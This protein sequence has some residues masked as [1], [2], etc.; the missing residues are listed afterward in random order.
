MSTAIQKRSRGVSVKR[1]SRSSAAA[2]ATEWT[3]R[4]SLPSQAAETS[5][6]T[7]AMSSSERTS[8]GVTS[9]E[10]TDDASSR[11]LLSI[12]SP[13]NV[14]ASSA[15]SSASRRAIAHAIE[16]LLATPSDERALS[17]EPAHGGESK[18]ARQTAGTLPFVR[19]LVASIALGVAL[20]GH[21]DGVCRLPADRPATRRDRDPPRARR[22]D[23]DSRRSSQR[24]DHGDPDA[25]RSAAGRVLAH[26]RRPQLHAAAEHVELAAKAYVAK[27]QRAQRA[28]AATLKRAIPEATVHRNYTILLNGMAVELPATELARAAKLSFARK[29]YP[30]YR[31]TLALNRSPGLIGAGAL[32]AAGG[33]TGE[34]MK[35]AVVDDGVDPRASSSTRR[36]SATRPATR[37][38]APSGRRR[39]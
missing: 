35:I 9:S 19:R 12:R 6:K 2:K 30:S 7:R 38:A 28:A 15:P 20:A 23:H 18:A 27:L 31:Y 16:R 36:A 34:G 32:A 11:T 10:P 13:W 14:K 4:S 37:R 22:N 5:P 17:V 25:R 33:G 8:H 1:P 3:S 21:G 29:L 39:R 26:A 24:A